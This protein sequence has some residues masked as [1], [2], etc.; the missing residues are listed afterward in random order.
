MSKGYWLAVYKTI[1]DADRLAE[2]AKQA[3]VAITAHGGAFLARG[4]PEA[5]LEGDNPTRTVLIEF[6][7]AA[8]AI[9]AYG[10]DDYKKALDILG[11]AADRD[12]R[13]LNGL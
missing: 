2:Y 5:M 4:M 10:S 1:H 8:A 12:I 7:S 3:S 13:V 6:P 11:K 9:A